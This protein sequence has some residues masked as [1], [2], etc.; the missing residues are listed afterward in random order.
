M[1]TIRV[2]GVRPIIIQHSLADDL[3]VMPL[4]SFTRTLATRVDYIPGGRFAH[5]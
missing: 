5:G 1:A 4:V 3:T 2:L